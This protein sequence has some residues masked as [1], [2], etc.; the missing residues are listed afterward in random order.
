MALTDNIVAYYKFEGN[1]NDSVSTNNGTDTSMTYSS[2]APVVF[3]Q[4]AVFNGST[5]KISIPSG[6]YSIFSGTSNFTV[7]VWVKG[8]AGYTGLDN[9]IFCATN[10]GNFHNWVQLEIGGGS[11]PEMWRGD[12]VTQDDTTGTTALT[13]TSL[14]YM[15]TYRYDGTDERIYV[16]GTLDNTPLASTRTVPT[17]SVGDI[18]AAN[19]SGSY[20]SFFPSSLDEMGFWSRA[21]TTTE[22]TQLYNS[23]AGLQ[24]PFD[25]TTATIFT[26]RLLTLGV[27]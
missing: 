5:S 13:N 8:S 24:Y 6:V 9:R 17:T 23:G 18:G 27:G 4:Y 3:S 20:I 16:N 21:L 12:G 11:M 7:N 19:N 25:S 1:S 14:W 26:P 22:I 10:G 2:T 15:V